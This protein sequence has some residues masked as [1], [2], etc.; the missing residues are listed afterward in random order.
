MIAPETS[1]GRET[2]YRKNL[3]GEECSKVIACKK[4]DP[5]SSKIGLW[6]AQGGTLEAIKVE[7]KG[8]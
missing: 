7:I 4:L 5:L 6:L 2:Y 3:E 1:V 8:Y